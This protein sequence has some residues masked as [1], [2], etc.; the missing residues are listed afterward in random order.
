MKSP[1][2]YIYLYIIHNYATKLLLLSKFY[3]LIYYHL[4]ISAVQN[5]AIHV[6]PNKNSKTVVIQNITSPDWI[7]I[8]R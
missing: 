8:V 1:L 6:M 4:L 2:Y 7:R 3:L 5:Y